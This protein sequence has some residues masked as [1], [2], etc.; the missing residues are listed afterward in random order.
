MI[1]VWNA[2]MQ[3]AYQRDSRRADLTALM[4]K[5][6]LANYLSPTE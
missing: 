5:M 3:E 1:G 2:G 4:W 6:P